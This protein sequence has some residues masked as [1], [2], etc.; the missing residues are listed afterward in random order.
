[1]KNNTKK[2]KM[3]TQKVIINATKE[4]IERWEQ[5]LENWRNKT[6]DIDIFETYEML[7]G[8][9]EDGS[10]IDIDLVGDEEKEIANIRIEFHH[11]EDEP[12]NVTIEEEDLGMTNIPYEGTIEYAGT[13]YEYQ[14]NIVNSDKKA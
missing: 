3:S 14:I 1:M 13:K 12:G 2:E 8:K 4:E 5:H 11:F 9:A 10:Y 6:E 7:T